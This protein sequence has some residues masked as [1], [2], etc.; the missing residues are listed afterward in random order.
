MTL[1]KLHRALIKTEPS[2][3]AAPSSFSVTVS[4]VPEAD[5][6]TIVLFAATVFCFSAIAAQTA[7]ISSLSKS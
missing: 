7:T 3:G 6:I 5:T 1:A 2:G 4:T